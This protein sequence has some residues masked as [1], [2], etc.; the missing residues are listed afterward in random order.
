M[1]ICWLSR[2]YPRVYSLLLKR[3]RDTE[4]AH[5]KVKLE[6]ENFYNSSTFL[7]FSIFPFLFAS[8]QLQHS[9][10]FHSSNAK[11]E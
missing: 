1:D 9:A 4:R 10:R 11:N 6:N 2:N 5:E 8:P 7:S 3:F